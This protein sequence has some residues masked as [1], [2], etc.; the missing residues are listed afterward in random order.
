VGTYVSKNVAA[1]NNTVTFSGLSLAGGDASNYT[2]VQQTSTNGSGTIVAKTITPT[3]QA[4][5]KTYDGTATATLS[6]ALSSTDVYTGDTVT[7]GNT[8]AS[9]ADRHVAKDSSG[10]VVG[11]TVT[12]SGLSLGGDDASNYALS[13]PSVTTTAKITPKALTLAA[14]TDSKT[15]DGTTN[16]TGTV[17]AAALESVDTVTATQS[18]VS[19]DVLGTGG[20]T[21]QVKSGYTVNDGNGGNNY[22]VSTTTT[23]GTIAKA[24]LSVIANADARFVTLGDAPNYN[25]V[26]Y[27]GLVNG[28]TKAVLGGTLNITRTNASTN[29]AAGT[30]AGTLVASGLTSGN[31]NISYAN[32]DYTIVPANQLLIRTGNVSTGNVSTVYGTAP[33]YS[34]TAQ[35][36]EIKPDNTSVIHTLNQTGSG[37]SYTFSDGAGGSVSTVLKPYTVTSGSTTAAGVSSSGITV[38]GN[39]SVLDTSPVITGSNFTGAPVYVGVLTV[40]P[41]DLTADMTASNKVY[42]G[43]VLTTASGSSIDIVTGDKVSFANTS[44]TFANKN[45]GTGKT[46][47]VTGITIGDTDAGNYVLQNSTASATADVSKKDATITGTATSTTYNGLTQTQAAATSDG[48]LS[49]DLV[50]DDDVDLPCEHLVWAD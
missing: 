46:V 38:V 47:T 3:A 24:N 30:Y 32:G 8:G 7:F 50:V 4:S 15:Y 21:L 16:S 39:S 23:A 49:G 25:G 14:V 26:S 6:A 48:F 2:L 45:A 13:S 20:S 10:N 19:K 37:N 40:T 11:K 18:F 17:T 36:L 34:T 28:E 27:S 1:T 22:T 31:Y 44:A 43:G 42:D 29:V 35:Y 9:F 12:V 33:T 41:K 5:D